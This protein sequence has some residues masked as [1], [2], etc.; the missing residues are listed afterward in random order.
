MTYKATVWQQIREN[1]PL[2]MKIALALGIGEQAVVMAARPE[3]MSDTLTKYAAVKVVSEELG[4]PQEE[5]FE[6]ETE[7]SA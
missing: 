2:R 4:I 3:R 7:V 1:S 6:P 5:L